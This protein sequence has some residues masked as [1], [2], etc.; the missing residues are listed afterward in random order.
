MKRFPRRSANSWSRAAGTTEIYPFAFAYH[1]KLPAK[2]EISLRVAELYAGKTVYVYYLNEENQPVQAAME[3]VTEDARLTFST[4]HCSLWFIS[5]QAVA[6]RQQ[7]RGPAGMGMGAH[8]RGR[9]PPSR[10]RRRR[11]LAGAEKAAGRRKRLKRAQAGFKRQ[12]GNTSRGRKAALIR[13]A[14]RGG[15]NPDVFPARRARRAPLLPFR[16]FL[17]RLKQPKSLARLFGCFQNPT[18]G[19]H[20]SS[21]IVRR[22][23]PP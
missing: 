6:A 5:E 13:F 23:S 10:R 1:G 21:L 4:D 22:I 8:R 19:A 20:R 2:A 14:R 16:Y 12:N 7:R 18:G 15:G 9:G 11:R 17:D 3:T